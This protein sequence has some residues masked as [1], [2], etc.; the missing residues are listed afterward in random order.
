MM[1]G[2]RKKQQLFLKRIGGNPMGKKKVNGISK[3]QWIQTSY[4]LDGGELAA[5]DVRLI[6]SGRYAMTRSV[7]DHM[8]VNA[9]SRMLTYLYDCLAIK[10][11]VDLS[12]MVHANE[13]LSQDREE[14]GAQEIWRKTV[15]IVSHLELVPPH[16][17][18]VSF[19]LEQMLRRY[20]GKRESF[21]PLMRACYVHNEFLRIYPFERNNE[22]TARA[23]LNFELLAA[24][25][26][27]VAFTMDRDSY[28]RAVRAHLHKKDPMPFYQMIGDLL[29]DRLEQFLEMLS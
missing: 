22:A 29:Q 26:I 1:E 19:C 6:L 10:D 18:D 25:L 24:N 13:M 17:Q 8:T 5:E 3:L 2:I 23:M 11:K 7:Q 20:Y 16:P 12:L 14:A 21:D 27:P 4:A 9:Y 15:P 28:H